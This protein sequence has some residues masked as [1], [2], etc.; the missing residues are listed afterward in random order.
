MLVWVVNHYAIPPVYGGLNRHFYFSKELKKKNI[1][2][3][4]FTSSKIHNTEINLIKDS[5]LNKVIEFDE[6]EYTFIK[7]SDYS[8]NGFKRLLSFL[9]FPINVYKSMIAYKHKEFPD[10]IYA[11]SPELF[12]TWCAVKFA[13]KYRVPI[14]VEI[15]D[16]WPESIVSFT[17]F[18]HNNVIIKVLYKL[19]R[20][21]YENA[22]RIIFTFEG[23]KDYIKEKKWDVEN[24][25][26]IS[27]NKVRYLNNGVDLELFDKNVEKYKIEDDELERK[28]VFKVV[29]TGSIRRANS[30]NL[31][32]DAVKILKDTNHKVSIILYGDGTEKE[33]L[34]E[35]CEK[36]KLTNVH[37]R[38]RVDKKYVPSILKRADAV[39][40]V[41]ETGE[42]DKY[43]LSLNKLFDYM[44]SGKPVIS[45]IETNYDNILKYNCGIVVTKNSPEAIAKG[46]LQIKNLGKS[47]YNE[48]CSNAK[49]AAED[50]DFKKLSN[51]LNNI[52]N[53]MIE[54]KEHEVK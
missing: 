43:G 34:I 33:S 2:T 36:H 42:I 22:D 19:E 30:L 54:E 16:L 39:I 23:G 11:S 4:I 6:V 40:F 14:I 49:L 45:N 18:T 48:Y 35:E 15:R 51:D 27:L 53:E 50:F 32:I 46:I 10:I 9:Q 41:G 3:R 20:W 25:G 17:R 52:F 47:T 8:G 1:K 12:A 21:I 24:G 7:T 28:D 38:N 13:K 26:K 5:K 37:F 31:L 29:Y 44:A